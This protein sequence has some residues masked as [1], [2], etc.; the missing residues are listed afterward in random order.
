MTRGTRELKPLEPR[1][2]GSVGI[3]ACGPTVY[4]A[5]TSATRGRTSSSRSSSGSSSTRATSHARRQHHRHQRQDLRRRARGGAR[6]EDLAREMAAPTWP[7]PSG[8]GLGRP[9][10][11][12]LATEYVEPIVDLIE[13]LVERGHAYEA[14]GDVYFRVRALPEYG[15]LSHRDVDQMDQGEGV[16]GADRKEDPLDFALWKAQKADEDTAWASPWGRGG[17]AGTSSAPRWPRSC[18]APSSRSTAAASTSCSRTTRTRRRRRRRGA[19]GRSRRI[20]MHNGMIELEA[21][22]CPSRSATSAGWPT[23]STRWAATR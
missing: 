12:P 14:G 13:A 1:D 7:T 19:G 15:E 21:T 4:R 5:S 6:S 23:R 2:P 16:E 9:D 20:W 22:R 18:S 3:Y 17:R 10:D 11:E 8:S